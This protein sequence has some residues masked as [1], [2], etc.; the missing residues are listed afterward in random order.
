MKLTGDRIKELRSEANI[1]MKD[2]AQE[3]GV[4]LDKLRKIEKDEKTPT[5]MQM[6]LLSDKFNVS[7]DYL[8]GDSP[9]R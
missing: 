8:Y 6:M 1:T 3:L 9:N 7:I 2:L 5:Y 4:T